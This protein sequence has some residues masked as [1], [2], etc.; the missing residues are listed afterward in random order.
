[1]RDL[2]LQ[3][4]DSLQVQPLEPIVFATTHAWGLMTN[5]K[6]KTVRAASSSKKAWNRPELRAVVPAS[7]TRG[8]AFP[9]GPQEDLS[10]NL[11]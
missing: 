5:Q 11:S 6:I 10:Y 1:M 3:V 7:H 9:N 8:G 4:V 2:R